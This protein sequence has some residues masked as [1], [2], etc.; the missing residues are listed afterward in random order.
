M[1]LQLPKSS[2]LW[3]PAVIVAA[4]GISVLAYA[5]RSKPEYKLDARELAQMMTRGTE[6]DK[7]IFATYKGV[8]L[9]LRTEIATNCPL[10]RGRE[11]VQLGI[12]KNT[13]RDVEH[14]GC[15][16]LYDS[17][18]VTHTELNEEGK[19]FTIKDALIP[20]FRVNPYYLTHEL[21]Y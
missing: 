6:M 17:K 4:L 3:V 14:K 19:A 11:F 21:P 15:W 7:E 12:D 2:K 5:N 18:I 1:D 13:L 10:P 16:T 9:V 20:E 8:M